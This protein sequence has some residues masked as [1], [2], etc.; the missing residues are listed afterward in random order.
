M[1]RRAFYSAKFQEHDND[2]RSHTSSF[3]RNLRKAENLL[4]P[5]EQV[6]SAPTSSNTNYG[7]SDLEVFAHNASSTIHP[8]TLRPLAIC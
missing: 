5:A 2:T 3:I 6:P 7:A 1:K 4:S 8:F